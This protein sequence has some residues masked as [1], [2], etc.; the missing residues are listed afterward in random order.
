M[1]S[2][3][4]ARG[5]GGQCRYCGWVNTRV[6][7]RVLDIHL[8]TF[9][10]PAGVTMIETTAAGIPGVNYLS[11]ES[12]SNGIIPVILPVLNGEDGARA[13]QAV[14][15]G[16]LTAQDGRTLFFCARSPAD[17]VADAQ[18]L[19]DDAALRRAAGEAARLAFAH[20]NRPGLTA[21][22]F[23]AHLNDIAAQ[24]RR[25]TSGN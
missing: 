19:I 22:Q 6:Y 20:L 11:E 25:A 7:A 2:A 17:Y 9:P 3:F 24:R 21:V 10:F 8:D 23:A 16:L 5:I 15:R 1:E 12:R 18:R 14:V 4:D 13:D